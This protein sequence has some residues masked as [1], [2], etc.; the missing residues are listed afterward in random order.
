MAVN[1]R[2]SEAEADAFAET[3]PAAQS[4]RS[5]FSGFAVAS[6]QSRPAIQSPVDQSLLA[7]RE[8]ESSAIPGRRTATAPSTLLQRRAAELRRW[9][10]RV[11]AWG[12]WQGNEKFSVVSWQG[13]KSRQLAV[14]S[15]QEVA[16]LRTSQRRPS[17]LQGRRWRMELIRPLIMAASWRVSSHQWRPVVSSINPTFI[18]TIV[19]VRTSPHDPRA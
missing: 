12:S 5:L 10:L 14:F 11:S 13:T 2:A 7:A 8:L 19:C 4:N 16:N 15:S 6:H 17:R 1:F 18:P 3:R 9:L